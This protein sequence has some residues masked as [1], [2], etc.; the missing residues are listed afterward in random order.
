MQGL[1]D[2]FVLEIV[3]GANS[4]RVEIKE[5]RKVMLT[6]NVAHLE[7]KPKILILQCCQGK[8]IQTRMY[9]TD[10]WIFNLYKIKYSLPTI[11]F[12]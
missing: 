6:T 3:Y 12:S 9:S 7:G 2:W 4:C 11:R 5:I 10:L 8:K 1:E